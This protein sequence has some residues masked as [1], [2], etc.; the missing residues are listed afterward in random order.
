MVM[1]L[2]PSQAGGKLLSGM[3]IAGRQ[4]FNVGNR[5]SICSFS[6]GPSSPA[7]TVPQLAGGH[8]RQGRDRPAGDKAA[9][10]VKAAYSQDRLQ[11]PKKMIC[12]ADGRPS[13]MFLRKS[14]LF[15]QA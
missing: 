5:R 14:I 4:F 2:A 10:K 12:A 11:P 7:V 6:T 15:I 1:R 13:L 8:A 3:V 9:H